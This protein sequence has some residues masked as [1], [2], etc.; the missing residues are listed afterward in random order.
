VRQD[1]YNLKD[2]REK[3]IDEKMRIECR[4]RAFMKQTVRELY[5]V[6]PFGEL[7]VTFGQL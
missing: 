6:L 2:G 4:Y 5:S 7:S 3:E 1:Q